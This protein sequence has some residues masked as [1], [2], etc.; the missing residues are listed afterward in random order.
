MYRKKFFNLQQLYQE[1]VNQLNRLQSRRIAGRPN[2]ELSNE[3][4]RLILDTNRYNQLLQSIES[5]LN[6]IEP[7]LHRRGRPT[8]E[9]QNQIENFQRLEEEFNAFYQINQSNLNNQNSHPI[10]PHLVSNREQR[11]IN[12][13][14]NSLFNAANLSEDDERSINQFQSIF[15]CSLTDSLRFA[16][17]FENYQNNIHLNEC[18]ICRELSLNINL[19]MCNRCS[20]YPIITNQDLI[21]NLALLNPFCELNNMYPGDI[22]LQ[23]QGLSQIEQIL[24]SPIKPIVQVFHLTANGQYGYRGQVINFG[25]DITQIVTQLPHLLNSI[26]ELFIVR[27]PNLDLSRFREFRVRKHKV[28]DA[29]SWLINNNQRYRNRISINQENINLLPY[30]DVVH[31][32]IQQIELPANNVQ[33]SSQKELPEED[34][35]SE[36]I[37]DD[38]QIT[39]VFNPIIPN[40]RNQ[41]NNALNISQE[42]TPVLDFPRLD[43]NPVN[44]LT[45]G[46]LCLAY[47]CL[48]PY[49][50]P[51]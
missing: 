51:I 14:Q 19:N 31:N 32:Y 28:F 27:D 30:D 17:I 21:T 46:Y 26:S 23:L 48:F 2:L 43:S 36:Q 18:S 33:Q 1:K 29:L 20:N 24:I 7:L 22:P 47:P 10:N 34:D 37:V 16:S 50:K 5:T 41:I 42:S 39:G 25:Q 11:L 49:G 3:I 8:N 40:I 38:L 12:R 4:N 45:P 6:V 15:N 44:E 13:Q 35:I 9:F